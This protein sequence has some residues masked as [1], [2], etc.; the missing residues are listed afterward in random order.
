MR[1]SSG[2]VPPEIQNGIHA[3]PYDTAGGGELPAHS[4]W[5]DLIRRFAISPRPNIRYAIWQAM[6]DPGAWIFHIVVF[7]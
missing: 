2:S 1:N 7:L 3:F 5:I 6:E 4:T